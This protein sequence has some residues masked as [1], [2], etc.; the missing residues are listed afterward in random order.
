ME[1]LR[2]AVIT[3]LLVANHP[4]NPLPWKMCWVRRKVDF[5]IFKRPSMIPIKNHDDGD[6]GD[7]DDDDDDDGSW[8]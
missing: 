3:W 1:V 2:S 7:D 5:V 4:T 8:C 6:D